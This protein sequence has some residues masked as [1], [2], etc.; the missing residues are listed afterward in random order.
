MNLTKPLIYHSVV[1][2]DKP[3]LFFKDRS[4]TYH[5]LNE[6]VNRLANSLFAM[7]VQK[8]ERVS[9]WMENCNEIVEIYLG[10]AKIGAPFAPVNPRLTSD[11]IAYLI[12]LAEPS[13]LFIDERYRDDF[14][15]I[16]VQLKSIRNVIY[17]GEEYDNLLESGAVIEPDVKVNLDDE[18]CYLPTGGTTGQPKLVVHA[19]ERLI[20]VASEQAITLGINA[21]DR[22]MHVMPLYHGAA[23]SVTLLPYL[24]AGASHVIL[25]KADPTEVLKTIEKYKPT[26][27]LIL[28]PSFYLW[29]T[30]VPDFEKYDLSSLRIWGTGAGPFPTE[31]KKQM[32]ERMPGLG[33]IFIY[34][35]TELGPGGSFL[36]PH[37]QF[38]KPGSCG[39]MQPHIEQR[40][41]DEQKKDVPFGEVG[42]LIVRCPSPMKGFFRNPKATEAA[43]TD[44]WVHTGDMFY[45]DEEGY[46]YF[47]D[48]KKD[49]IKSGGLNV[50]A[51]EVEEVI[52]RHANVSDVAVIGVADAKWGEA[53]M[54]II[55]LK[56]P[57]V[58]IIEELE[59]LCREHLAG[60]KVP[61]QFIFREQLPHNASGKILK[62]QLRKEYNFS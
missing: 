62:N 8:G 2:A 32:L 42:E 50:Y 34:G 39:K 47:V 30:Q 60:Y 3:A 51:H 6:R 52:F 18:L 21:D 16:R 58:D 40:L 57:Q 19:H 49:M 25:E 45:Q 14:E 10:I 54:A 36:L 37:E 24:Y 29:M 5:E 55:V 27:T 26:G 23:I 53:I 35:L 46:L 13:I 31:L 28:P 33:L 11:E 59:S 20:W 48:R 43:I 7:G 12:Q 9:V 22:A 17:L 56:Q 15:I 44:G 41:I 4:Y 38:T 61:K 1:H